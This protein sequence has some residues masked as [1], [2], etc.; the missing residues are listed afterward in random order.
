MQCCENHTLV[1]TRIRFHAN[2]KPNGKILAVQSIDTF[3]NQIRTRIGGEREGG[4][5]H[6]HAHTMT[7]TMMMKTSSSSHYKPHAVALSISTNLTVTARNGR[8]TKFNPINRQ[9]MHVCARARVRSG[10]LPFSRAD[11]LSGPL[12]SSSSSSSPRRA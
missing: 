9:F 4:L 12:P 8:N 6:A 5:L 1:D 10:S 3:S 11:D 7:M 2:D